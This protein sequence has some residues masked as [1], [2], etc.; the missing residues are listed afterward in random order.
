MIL[1][2]HNPFANGKIRIFTACALILLIS[3]GFTTALIL[4][5][6]ENRYTESLLGRYAVQAGELERRIE[7]SLRFGKSLPHFYGMADLLTEAM[8]AMPEKERNRMDILLADGEI[9]Y[10]TQRDLVGTFPEKRVLAFIQKDASKTLRHGDSHVIFRT[11]EDV[12]G[13]GVGFVLFTIDHGPVREAWKRMLVKSLLSGSLF[14]SAGLGLLLLGLPA[15]RFSLHR[16]LLVVICLCQAGFIAERVRAYEADLSH[17]YGERVFVLNGLLQKE[18]EHLL[19]LGLSLERLYKVDVLLAR[20]LARLP[21]VAEIRITDASSRV[22][23]SSSGV[24]SRENAPRPWPKED[25]DVFSIPLSVE[26]EIRGYIRS[27]LSRAHIRRQAHA[28]YWDAGTVA[29]VSLFLG[30][31]LLAFLSRSRKRG[32]AEIPAT[33]WNP[34]VSRMRVMAFF[35]F[36]GTDIAISFLP[37]HMAVLYQP[38]A[39]LPKETVLGLPITIQMMC[40]ALAF[41][42]AGKWSDRAGWQWPFLTG[43]G[44]AACGFF[45]AAWAQAP[46]FYLLGMGVVGYGYGL[47]YMAGQNFVVAVSSRENRGIGLSEFYAGCIAGSICGSAVGALLA[48]RTGYP[49]VFFLG[50]LALILSLSASFFYLKGF[51][52]L[53][54]RNDQAPAEKS[55]IFF[56][57]DRR[58]LAVIFC[59]SL[60]AAIALVG[61][62][63]YFSPIYLNAMGVSQST[64]GRFFMLYGVCMIYL[65][66]WITRRLG[67]RLPRLPIALA[68]LLGSAAFGI[69]YLWEGLMAV[70]LGILLLG[71]AACFNAA[72]NA[73]AINLP[74]SREVGEGRAMGLIFFVARLGQVAGPLIFSILLAA[75]EVKEAILI[76]GLS[77]LFLTLLFGALSIPARPMRGERA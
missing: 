7:Q 41:L 50:G 61:F 29:L 32:D 25:R 74:V 14:F 66:P 28:L 69:F 37:L 52:G 12:D 2:A 58:I 44:L 19:R 63:N 77:Y 4:L 67:S 1:S 45:M 42:G 11:L 26:G 38:I 53:A 35:F 56:F 23:H 17:L 24:F 20:S 36:F 70:G 57:K 64:I 60:P 43:L 51:F 27:Q 49:P 72:R 75:G 21:E 62:M 48:D 59:S 39:G 8:V 18:V 68:G 54:S 31:E 76:V 46:L 22:L 5:T 34:G 6:L 65:A 30:S 3:L 40:T 71:F 9:R 15:R 55:L 16:L 73:Y 47:A 10:S 33:T 13:L